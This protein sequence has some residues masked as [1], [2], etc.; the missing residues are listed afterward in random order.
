MVYDTKKLIELLKQKS[1]QLKLDLALPT[2][3]PTKVTSLLDLAV[4]ELERL[5]KEVGRLSALETDRIT[6]LS[7][8]ILNDEEVNDLLR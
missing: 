4:L 2:N 6:T 5:D 1:N 3:G 7:R 8:F